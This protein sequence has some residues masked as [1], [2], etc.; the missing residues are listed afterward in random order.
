MK[1]LLLC[2]LLGQCVLTHAQ[3]ANSSN[4]LRFRSTNQIGFLSGEASTELQLQT[5]NG[6]QYKT[7]SMG[8]GVGLDYYKER[9]VPLFL[10]VQKNLLQKPST[11]FVY[12]DGGYHFAWPKEKAEEWIRKDVE[13]GLYY[14]LGI[15]YRFPTFRTGAIHV[16]LGYN[17][18]QM[19]EKI[20]QNLWRSSFPLPEDFQRFDYTL[21]RYSFKMGLTL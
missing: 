20:N 19:S 18:K 2:L 1:Q 17:V 15:G 3:Q 7:Y 5:V 11:P 13:G 21:R 8:I 6:I 10:N 16:S 4:K 9:S 14:D 12:A